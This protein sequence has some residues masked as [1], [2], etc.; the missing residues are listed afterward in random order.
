MAA[1]LLLEAEAVEV[2]DPDVR[3]CQKRWSETTLAARLQI[4]KKARYLLAAHSSELADA[5]PADLHRTRADSLV[6]EVLPLLAACRFLERRARSILKPR[7]LGRKGLPFWL[8]GVQSFVERAPFGVV[9]VI[10]PSNYPLLLAGVQALQGL[11]A[12]NAVVWKPGR[13]GREVA[14][15]LLRTLE[16]A[17][18][19]SGLLRITDESAEAGVAEI[20]GEPDK[21]FFTG[22]ARTG[23]AVLTQAAKHLTPTVVELSGCD[24]VVV[25]PSAQTDRV[26]DA[27]I[28][29]M[30]L[31]GSATCMA[32]RRLILVGSGH[33]DLLTQLRKGF[34]KMAGI[35]LQPAIR[36]ELEQLVREAISEGAL[37]IDEVSFSSTRPILVENVRPEMRIAQVDLFAPVLSVI[38]VAD[39][40]A[41]LTAEA[42][43]PFGLTVSI[44][45]NE[46]EARALGS[47]MNVGSLLIN[48]LIVPTADPRLPFGG[49]RGSGF[50]TTR[51]TE[52]LL[53]MT[54]VRSVAIRRSRGWRHYEATSPAH[55][56]FFSG[57]IAMAH[58]AKLR[59]RVDGLRKLL[60]GA[61]KLK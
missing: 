2:L 18:L 61:R 24:A 58:H 38:K 14:M 23:R 11:A 1:A 19:P 60:N 17:G 34:S 47:Q 49:R 10:A 46:R 51:G 37:V 39:T 43:C 13:G 32:P 44:F 8:D 53:E 40:D 26:I 16:C 12:G 15:V 27:L 56:P 4:L 6:A 48:D 3:A 35:T 20:E 55:E 31:N 29:G 22:S 57:L 25:L 5:M 28:F 36:N 59:G 52:G 50:G 33:D 42:L 30:R 45:G 9:L 41:A 21:I 7:K 54:A